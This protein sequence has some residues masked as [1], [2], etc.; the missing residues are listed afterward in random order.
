MSNSKIWGDLGEFCVHVIVG[1]VA[2]FVVSLIA[3]LLSYWVAFLEAHGYN[4]FVVKSVEAFEYFV[5][6]LDFCLTGYMM[7]LSSYKLCKKWR[8]ICK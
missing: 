7:V 1:A 6:V 5:L 8:N 3:V 4:L 2:F